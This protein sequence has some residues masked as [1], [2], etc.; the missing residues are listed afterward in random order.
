MKFAKAASFL[1]IATATTS[2]AAFTFTVS[3]NQRRYI[4]NGSMVVTSRSSTS[5]TSCNR[6]PLFFV[7]D[8]LSSRSF[9]SS[10]SPLK[11]SETLEKE[12]TFE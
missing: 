4:N 11:M 2:V 12:E 6:A 3:S 7:A 1:S 10:C 9:T 5:S 8:S